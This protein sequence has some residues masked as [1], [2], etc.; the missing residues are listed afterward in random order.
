M[1]LQRTILSLICLFVAVAS[2]LE[3]AE[4]VV[5]PKEKVTSIKEALRMATNGDTLLIRQGHYAE[6][7]IVIDKSVTILG[8][9]YPVI[10]GEGKYQIFTITADNVHVEGLE[11]RN[12]GVS[13]IEDNAAIK[14][15]GG[16]SAVI[17]NNRLVDNFFGIY[18]AKTANSKVINNEIVAE[19]R[20]EANSGNGIH[21][22]YCKNIEIRNNYI[23]GH[24]DGIYFE[25][26]EDAVV[27]ENVSENNLRYGLHFMFSHGCKYIENV[28]RQN[29]AGVAVM[30]T[31][32]VVMKKNHFEKNW[33]PASYGLL[34]KEITDSEITE[35]LF[36][37]NSIGFFIEGSN[38]VEVR[39]NIF[40]SNGWA[41]KVMAN[42]MDNIFEKN[43]F[44][45]N[46]FDVA[47]NSRQNFNTFRDN[48]WSHYRGY[49]INKDGIGDVPYHPVRLFS[50][51][52]EKQ[53]PA[54]ILLRSLFIDILDVAERFIPIL[55]PETLID[56]SPRMHPLPLKFNGHTGMNK[57]EKYNG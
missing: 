24:R 47:T 4:I 36:L 49:D 40:Q 52:I 11:F 26:V 6:G 42:S 45:G 3:A 8:E 1:N 50:L 55:T 43:N 38:R 19:A 2:G 32:R 21:L 56:S 23:T 12:S 17:Q 13:F 51:I 7:P 29:G 46:T 57:G 10:D 16:M 28:F 48:Y 14:V 53:P 5:G 27:Y 31:R 18:L 37:Q 15:D 34:L 33:G 39:H 44:L 25:F 41:I 9:N 30:Y 22:W 35:N 20:R 54:I